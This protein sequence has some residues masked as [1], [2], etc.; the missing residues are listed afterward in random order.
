MSDSP[1][2]GAGA[3]FHAE[4]VEQPEEGVRLLDGASAAVDAGRAIRR[5]R[6][7]F[8]R[9]VG[10]GSSDRPVGLQKVTLAA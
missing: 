7:R 5:R 8:L 4:L 10:H 1:P 6:P 3:C 2:E 9:L